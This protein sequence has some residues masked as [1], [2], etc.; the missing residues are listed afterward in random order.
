MGEN[1][2]IKSRFV[3]DGHKTNTPSGNDLLVSGFEGLSSYCI[4]NDRAK[5][6]RRVGMSYKERLS[7]IK[8][9]KACMGQSDKVTYIDQLG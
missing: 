9:H 1:F 3:A 8:V 6:L 4:N 5:L 2:R 7:Y